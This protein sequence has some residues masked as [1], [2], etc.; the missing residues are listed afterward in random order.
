MEAATLVA[1][2]QQEQ[3]NSERRAIE[4][5]KRMEISEVKITEAEEVAKHCKANEAAAII[6]LRNEKVKTEE[7]ERLIVLHQT[8]DS[9]HKAEISN[10]QSRLK[11]TLV[12][13]ESKDIE[14]AKSRKSAQEKEILLSKSS[15]AFEELHAELDS[16]YGKLV[17]L[18]Q[19]FELT[20]KESEEI[21]QKIDRE[22]R[23]LRKKLQDEIR[24][25]DKL[26][27][28]NGK[29]QRDNERIV[30]KLERSKQQ[31][32]AEQQERNEEEQRRRKLGPV[33]YINDLHRDSLNRSMTMNYSKLHSSRSSRSKASNDRDLSGKE[34]SISSSRY[35]SSRT[36][37]ENREFD[38]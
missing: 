6:S 34:N 5:E 18:A 38:G 35:Y 24:R 9:K 28:E 14:L 21:I 12:E 27:D 31:L 11:D 3:V 13:I 30:K 4:A 22:A 26:D 36:A 29:L 17:C 16:T 37:I 15:K 32:A 23:Q 2:L 19:A 7:L 8:T 33:S 1:R 10:L 20:E 25:N